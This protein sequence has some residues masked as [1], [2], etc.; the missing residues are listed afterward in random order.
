[1]ISLGEPTAMKHDESNA[2]SI[3]TSVSAD[4]HGML[5]LGAASAG[6]SKWPAT[7]FVTVNDIASPMFVLKGFC[8]LYGHNEV[9]PPPH[10]LKSAE[11]KIR[12]MP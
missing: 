2:H 4:C 7:R 8:W 11:Y 12:F 5:R 3:L 6:A 10:A 9:A 1:M